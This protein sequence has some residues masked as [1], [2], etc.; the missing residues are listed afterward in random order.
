M[1]IKEFEKVV[2]D[3][4]SVKKTLKLLL[5]VFLDIIFLIVK[6]LSVLLI[7]ASSIVGKYK[8]VLEHSILE[9]PFEVMGKDVSEETQNHQ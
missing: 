3:I 5:F 4:D 6:S 9:K 7:K 1:K 8:D 2:R